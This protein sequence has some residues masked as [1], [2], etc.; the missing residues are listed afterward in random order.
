MGQERLSLLVLISIERVAVGD[1]HVFANKDIE[2]II[3]KF[4]HDPLRRINHKS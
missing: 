3:L 1:L 2:T 4:V